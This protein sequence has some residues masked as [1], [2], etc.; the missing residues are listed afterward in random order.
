V[1]EPDD[2]KFRSSVTL[3][4]AVSDQP[5]YREAINR[6]Y[7]GQTDEATPAILANWS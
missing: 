3:F 1:L 2:L 6:F 4:D 7:V 5:L